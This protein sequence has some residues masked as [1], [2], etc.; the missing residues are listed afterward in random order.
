MKNSTDDFVEDLIDQTGQ[1]QPILN[2]YKNP[3]QEFFICLLPSYIFL[4]IF[5]FRYCQILRRNYVNN[6]SHNISLSSLK[7]CVVLMSFTYLANL[8][9]TFLNISTVNLDPNNVRL[10]F[11]YIIPILSWYISYK[12]TSLETT[13]KAKPA[14]YNQ[15]LFYSI[16]EVAFVYKLISEPQVCTFLSKIN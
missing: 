3:K 5:L 4:I 16:S 12:L 6:I 2:Q 14:C 15:Y 7:V 13:R 11:L 10:A 1:P 8:I 9:L